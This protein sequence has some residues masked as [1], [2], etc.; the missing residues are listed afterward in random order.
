MVE[1]NQK[2]KNIVRSESLNCAIKLLTE[3]RST[4]TVASKFYLRNLWEKLK[5]STN[6]I[7]SNVNSQL[8]ESTIIRWEAFYD[9]IVGKKS[10][11]ELKVAYLCGP[12][13]LNDL[14]VLVN[15][16]ILPENVWAFE[17]ETESYNMAKKKALSSRF[18]FLKIVSLDF[19]AFIDTSPIKFDI[20]YLDFC[21]PIYNRNKSQ[22]NLASL[23]ALAKSQALNSPGILLTNYSLPYKEQDQKGN[24]ILSWLT[25]NYLYPKSFL[26]QYKHDSNI[27]E[28][29][30]SHGLTIEDFHTTVKNDLSNFYGQF[31][32]RLTMDIFTYLVPMDRFMSNEKYL[33]WFFDIFDTKRQPKKRLEILVKSL[34]YFS[35]NMNGG[36]VISDPECYS[37]LWSF[38]SIKG[39]YKSK[40]EVEDFLKHGK[41]FLGQLSSY[42]ASYEDFFNKL[43]AYQFLIQEGIDQK[44]FYST[45][46]KQLELNWKPFRE[47]I[48]CDV[49][50]FH[51]LKDQLIRQISV[52]Y[53][54]NVEKTNRW[55]YK[56][57][58]TEMFMDL[59][60][61]DE[62]R[63]L[64][65]WM[66]TIDMIGENLENME[67]KLSFRYILDAL[68]KQNR[69]YQEEVFNGTAVIDMYT[70]G[71]SVKTFKERIRID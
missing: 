5:L 4:T 22:K 40:N 15:N 66:P 60:V 63:Y 64:Y 58:E 32:T 44:Q 31:V 9:S 37:T 33:N 16:G 11:S 47:H 24:D 45:N 35:N 51:Q 17:S 3:E 26:E 50:L 28:G 42:S 18:P 62:C 49:F 53:N 41:L 39:L 56:A 23:V 52:P 34:F 29:C 6:S 48:F 59:F 68:G 54:L 20:I 70:E 65:D 8:S 57:K 1:Y 67:Q 43:S 19:K 13:P 38:A 55:S 36:N 21:G 2:S 46:L 30:F 27:T 25:A 7:D 12:D 61:F 71:F 10:P 69:W 14:E